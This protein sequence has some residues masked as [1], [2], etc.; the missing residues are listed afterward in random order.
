MS[1][2]NRFRDSTQIELPCA[3]LDEHRSP[4]ESAF[5]VTVV[6]DETQC[7]IIGSPMEIKAVSN[8]LSRRGIALP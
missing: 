8:F 7:R 5:T 2:A 1:N 3:A 6:T 4:L